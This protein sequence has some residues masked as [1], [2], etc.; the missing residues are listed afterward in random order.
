MRNDELMSVAEVAAALGVSKTAVYALVERGTLPRRY[1]G[2]QLVFSRVTIVDLVRSAS[3]QS[4]SRSARTE[5]EQ[6][7]ALGVRAPKQLRLPMGGEGDG[8]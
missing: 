3:F 8:L 2:R 1:V 4:R 5:E 7:R 6:L